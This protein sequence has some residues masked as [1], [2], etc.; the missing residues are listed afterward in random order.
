MTASHAPHPDGPTRHEIRNPEEPSTPVS[1]PDRPVSLG[2]RAA[3]APR[4][5]FLAAGVVLGAA[6]VGATWAVLG[7]AGPDGA[8]SFTIE[9][10]FTVRD[11]DILSVGGSCVTSEGYDDIGDGTEVTV[12]DEKGAVVA[13]GALSRP[14]Y[15][16]GE[17]SYDTD[18][19]SY[20][21]TVPKVPGGHPFYQVEVSHRGKVKLSEAEARAGEL[22]AS[23][24]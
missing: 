15:R 21:V 6:A 17:T 1:A 18:E 9:G 11:E 2:A 7:S 19:C 13:T 8:G 14:K 12:Y 4:A 22:D 24:G 10:A 16:E 23:L 3:A 5:A 20:K